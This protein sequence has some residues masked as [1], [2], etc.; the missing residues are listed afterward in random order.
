MKKYLLVDGS[1]C[2]GECWMTESQFR[3]ECLEARKVASV[4]LSWVL[5]HPQPE[6]P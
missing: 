1:D 4:N 3:K 5:V 6:R 2:Y